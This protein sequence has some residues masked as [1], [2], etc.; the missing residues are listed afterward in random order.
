[1]SPPIKEYANDAAKYM[2]ALM[3][4]PYLEQNIYGRQESR[5]GSLHI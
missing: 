2:L 5:T 3:L 1:M 4:K